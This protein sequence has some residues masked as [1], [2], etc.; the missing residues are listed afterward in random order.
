MFPVLICRFSKELFVLIHQ[1]IT[2]LLV[3]SLRA[4]IKKIGIAKVLKINFANFFDC[5]L[6]PAFIDW[7]KDESNLGVTR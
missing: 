7:K 3:S 4:D 5:N 1:K 6:K 2:S